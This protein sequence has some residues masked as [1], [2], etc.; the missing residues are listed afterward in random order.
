MKV[1]KG[2]MM[3]TL[4]A[5]IN[6]CVRINSI[7][8]DWKET[9]VAILPKYRNKIFE[10]SKS[11]LDRVLKRSG[12][13]NNR[14]I[15]LGTF[16][17]K[18]LYLALD[19]RLS[20]WYHAKQALLRKEQ[21]SNGLKS[22]L[23]QLAST[24][25]EKLETMLGN[26]IID[27]D[28]SAAALPPTNLTSW[29]L[30][31]CYSHSYKEPVLYFQAH[32]QSGTPLD[33]G[34]ILS[35]LDFGVEVNEGHSVF[36]PGAGDKI[37][38]V[39]QEHH[40]VLHRPFYMLHPCQTGQVMEELI[41]KMDQLSHGDGEERVERSRGSTPGAEKQEDGCRYLLAWLSV[42]GRPVGGAPTP[43]EWQDAMTKLKKTF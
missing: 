17:A 23:D 18:L 14:V 41:Q 30:H 31:I 36:V 35:E 12:S 3:P 38:A 7:T 16:E 10:G 6:A 4:T 32:D 2:V 5:I 13:V 19:S 27:E 24:R 33:P 43:I 39:S 20:K 37:P 8:D 40:P 22:P 29:T 25:S 42:A 11:N 28:P 26:A 34:L 21:T 1:V 15:Q 9:T